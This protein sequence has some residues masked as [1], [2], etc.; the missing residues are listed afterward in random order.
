MLIELLPF[1]ILLVVVVLFG[2]VI[3]HMIGLKKSMEERRV[4]LEAEAANYRYRPSADV[5]DV[6]A[7]GLRTSPRY[8]D[9]D[10]QI[11]H[12][13]AKPVDGATRYLVD[14]TSSAGS[15]KSS[16]DRELLFLSRLDNR[17][18]PRFVL[19]PSKIKLPKLVKMT[20]DKL[21]QFRYPGFEPVPMD[22]IHPDLQHSLMYAED[23]GSGIQILD[24]DAVDQLTR[25]HGWGIESTGAWLLAEKSDSSSGP[26]RKVP[27]IVAQ[28][29]EFDG[30]ISA[31]ED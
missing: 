24:G 31:F 6:V 9:H 11:D 4:Q 25:A 13:L 1:A 3:R 14:F 30:L 10:I 19:H 17:S 2:F 29:A 18:L 5:A 27:D 23:R 8:S 26:P 21:I 22:G 20:L 7:A 28:L 16:S 12:L 15:S